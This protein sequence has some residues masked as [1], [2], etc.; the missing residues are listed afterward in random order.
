MR[1][2]LELN[3]SETSIFQRNEYH[4]FTCHSYSNYRLL[5][6]LSNQNLN[7]FTSSKNTQ[8]DDSYY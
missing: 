2:P 7:F 8:I 6:Y 1:F 4:I 3:S 5:A